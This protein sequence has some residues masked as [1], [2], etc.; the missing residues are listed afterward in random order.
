[1]KLF[2]IVPGLRV[3]AGSFSKMVLSTFLAYCQCYST[4]FSLLMRLGKISLIVCHSQAFTSRLISVSKV[5]AYLFKCGNITCTRWWD[6]FSSLK[7]YATL[8]FPKVIH[9]F[10]EASIMKK[11]VL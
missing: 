1:V 6:T 10:E 5:E 7:L 8:I 2:D 11:Q 9:T 3:A 4:F